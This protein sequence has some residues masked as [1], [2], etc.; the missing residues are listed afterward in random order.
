MERKDIIY[1]PECKNSV[2]SGDLEGVD[3]GE[4]YAAYHA[5]PGRVSREALRSGRVSSIPQGPRF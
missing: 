1:F 3:L 5:G 4:F 2:V